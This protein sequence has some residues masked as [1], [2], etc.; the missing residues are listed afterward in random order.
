NAERSAKASILIQD[1]RKEVVETTRALD[2]TRDAMTGISESSRRISK[3]IQVI[4]EIAFQ[5]NLL[6]LNAAVEAARAGAAGSGFAVVADEVRSL[7]RRSAQAARETTAK[8][9]DALN[10]TQ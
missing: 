10:K 7:A 1:V 8:I 4:D 9:E 5:T 6:A 3:I 2:Q